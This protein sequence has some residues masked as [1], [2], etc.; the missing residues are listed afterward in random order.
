[1]QV[2]VR[3]MH[4]AGTLVPKVLDVLSWTTCI[5]V[6]HAGA[7]AALVALAAWVNSFRQ[8]KRTY[9]LDFE[10]Y[11]PT[12]E[13][14]VSYK[15]FMQGSHE[16]GEFTQEAMDFQERIL[17]KS[18]LSQ[19]TFFPPGLHESPPKFNMHLARE[20]AEL[21]MFNAVADLLAKTGLRPGQID[22]L[23]VNCSLFNPTPSLACAL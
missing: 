9:L 16:V 4:E 19:E 17:N 13:M 7:V 20:E 15:R 12:E 22:I 5:S 2:Q 3:T 18:A 8:Y 11:R 23:V 10:C 21:V 1:M 14:K 6:A